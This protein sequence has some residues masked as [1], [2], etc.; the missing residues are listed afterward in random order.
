MWSLD[1]ALRYIPLAA[2]HDGREYLVEKYRNIVFTPASVAKLAALPTV[3]QWH[4][5]GMGVSKSYG[6]FSALPSVP[7]ELRAIIRE[8]GTPESVGV[9]PGHTLLD[10][11]FTE[12][13]LKKGLLANYPLVH[14]ASHFV[15][16]AGNDTESYLLLGGTG[17]EGQRLTLAEI[18]DDPD[19]SFNDVELLTLSA[20]N[21]AL[22]T[23]GDGREVDGLGI[24]AQ[25][26]GAKAVMAMLW[27]VYDPSTSELMQNFYRNW[28]T[29]AHV[30]KAEAL[31]RAQLAL[32]HGAPGQTPSTKALYTHPYYWAPFILIGNW[33]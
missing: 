8:T 24:L 15:F 32:L 28:T 33:Q 21:T 30:S 6:G 17:A 23:P 11:T 10:D 20:C 19:I 5:L 26:K 22:S 14:I 9:L 4:G 31:R 27:S 1:G 2:L 3:S 18:N 16:G 13:N 7:A 25:R 29:G 12:D